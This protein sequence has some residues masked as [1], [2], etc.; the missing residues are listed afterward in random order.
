VSKSLSHTVEKNIYLEERNGS[1]RYNVI[2]SGRKD[3]A[4]FSKE[5][6]SKGLLWA[7]RRRMAFLEEKAT[8]QP[9]GPLKFVHQALAASATV[10]APPRP[11]DIKMNDVFDN[12]LLHKLQDSAS[13]A[14]ERSRLKKLQGWFGGL[15]L[16]QFDYNCIEEWK[17]MRLKGELGSGRNPNRGPDAEVENDYADSSMS[18][19]VD[20]NPKAAMMTKHQ[21]YRVKKNGGVLPPEK[22]FPVSTQTVRHEIVLIRR[23]L[24]AYFDAHSL[25]FEH[26]AWLLAHWIMRMP[27]PDKANARTRRISDDEFRIILCELPEKSR[28]V[29]VFAMLSGLRRSEILSLSWQDFNVPK[30]VISLRAPAY[31]NGKKT[32]VHGRD[33]P[34]LPGAIAILQ[35]M[36]PQK[37]GKIFDWCP[38]G[39]TQ[40]WRRAADRAGLYDVRLHDTRREGLSR[41]V[42]QWGLGLEN[43][44]QFSGHSDIATL[45]KHYIQLRPEILASTLAAVPKENQPTMPGVL[46]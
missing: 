28:A 5:E 27:L 12:F 15:T 26:L 1:F 33:V 34:L 42:E 7:Q 3:S 38:S 25:V 8:G 39:L 9:V 24:K 43:V 40:L 4:T 45:Q 20:S 17:R 32:K 13:V 37:R 22:I 44:L 19:N 41:L 14:T 2:V 18:S 46:E 30:G 31:S 11:Q 35:K 36:R 23:C 16:G 21:K 6:L 29:V 10:A